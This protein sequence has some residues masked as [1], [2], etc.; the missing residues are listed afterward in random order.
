LQSRIDEENG[1]ATAAPYFQ[2]RIMG[3]LAAQDGH[4]EQQ[5]KCYPLLRLRSP[6]STYRRLKLSKHSHC[7]HKTSFATRLDLRLIVFLLPS[8]LLLA[9]CSHFHHEQHEYV[10]VSARQVYLHDRLA[11]VANRVALVTNGETLEV[12]ERGKRFTKVRTPKGEVGWIEDHAVIDDKLYAQFQDLAKKHANDPVVA[13]GELRDD[14]YLHVMPGRETPHFYLVA[15]STK[16]QLLARGTVEK[17]PAPGT[18]PAIKPKAPLS[19]PGASASGNVKSDANAPE[20]T[21]SALPTPPP[22]PPAME[23]WWLVRDSAGHIGWLLSGRLDVDVPDE[24]GQYAEGQ[25]MVAAYPIAKVMDSG[26]ERVEKEHGKDHGGKAG[27]H[28]AKASEVT[29]SA[30]AQ[31]G[32]KNAD[33]PA[34]PVNPEHTEYVTVLGPPRNGL[35]YDFDQIRVFTWSLNHHRYETGY[36]LHG[37]QGYLPVKISQENVNGQIEPTFSFR[38]AAGPNGSGDVIVDPETGVTQPK[39]VRTLDF[40]LEGNIVK[41]TGADQA[42]IILS[43]DSSDGPKSKQAAKKKKR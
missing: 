12:V 7:S 34:A 30:S 5:A 4:R 10:Y 31:D 20:K 6:V 16:V 36:R 42:P 17:A 27:K 1:G 9:A 18:L 32:S 29:E 11:A 22:A 28:P 23:D 43:H 13:S 25:R 33:S 15:G 14:L 37:I 26:V 19:T 39:V 2:L 21:A 8:F 41:R 40:R 35:P 38:I 3:G 24:V